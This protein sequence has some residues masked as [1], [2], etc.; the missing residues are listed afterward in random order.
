MMRGIL[1]CREYTYTMGTTGQEMCHAEGR[2]E[3]RTCEEAEEKEQF[4]KTEAD[5][6]LVVRRPTSKSNEDTHNKIQQ[7]KV[8]CLLLS[9]METV[10]YNGN[11][12]TKEIQVCFI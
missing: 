4:W 6:G 10:N 1:Y 3:G 8:I 7:Y 11:T 12:Q 2:K 5:G 9:I